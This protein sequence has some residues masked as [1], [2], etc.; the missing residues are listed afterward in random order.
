MRVTKRLS[1]QLLR[2][3]LLWTGQGLKTKNKEII[4]GPSSITMAEH[5]LIFRLICLV[6]PAI[7]RRCLSRVL[8]GFNMHKAFSFSFFFFLDRG[9]R[10]GRGEERTTTMN[11][12]NRKWYVVNEGDNHCDCCV[13]FTMQI[14]SSLWWFF[15]LHSLPIKSNVRIMQMVRFCPSLAMRPVSVH[16]RAF[17]SHSTDLLIAPINV[18]WSSQSW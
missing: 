3:G 14:R 10:Q 5:L 17:G 7:V 4:I 2:L 11:S 12:L 9:A 6:C 15:W 1:G 18:N 13:L 8:V 16:E